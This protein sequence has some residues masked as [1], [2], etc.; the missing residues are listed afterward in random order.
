MGNIAAAYYG[1]PEV[2]FHSGGTAPTAFNPRTVQTLQAIGVEVE[3]TG[4][5]AARGEPQTAN[6]IYRVRW[7]TPGGAAFEA[8]EYS[9]LYDDPANPQ[10]GFAA[11]M[12]SS[13]RWSRC[14]C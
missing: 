2:R 6:P 12:V 11:L 5:E 10:R 7:G 9:K 3:P 14:R 8:T 13:A 1:M 4:R